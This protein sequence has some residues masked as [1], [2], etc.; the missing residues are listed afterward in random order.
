MVIPSLTLTPNARTVLVQRYL[1]TDEQGHVV[2][3]P[4]GMVLRVARLFASVD[5]R[6]DPHLD[7]AG[8]AAPLSSK[9]PHTPS[10]RVHSS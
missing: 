10:Q 9:L 1:R 2:E 5:Q 8:Q 3:T 4:E 6:Y 7:V